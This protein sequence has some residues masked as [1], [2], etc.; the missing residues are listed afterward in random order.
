MGWHRSHHLPPERRFERNDLFPVCFSVG[1]IAAFALAIVSERLIVLRWIGL[2][3]TIYGA[4]YLLVHDLVIHH[5]LPVR[6]PAWRYFRWLRE[7]HRIH[8][9]YGGEPYGMLLPVVPRPAGAARWRRR[10]GR[11]STAP[12]PWPTQI[13]L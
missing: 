4:A 7:S 12:T 11:R 9:L 6:R 3:M 13:R 1:G 2:G 10:R 8:H 5:R